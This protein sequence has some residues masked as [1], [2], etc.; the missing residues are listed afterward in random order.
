MAIVVEV[1]NRNGQV[2]R[3]E[4][5]DK[6]LVTVGRAYHCD[7]ILA[8]PHIDAEH[9]VLEHNG[10]T[11]AFLC[12]DKRSLNG[13]WATPRRRNLV[14]EHK[15]RL[16]GRAHIF[17]GQTL[18]LGRTY[19]RV[20]SSH[21]AV[22]PAQPLSRWE[23]VDA[24]LSHWWVCAALALALILLTI[25]DRYLSAPQTG[26]LLQYALN[27]SY[28]LFSAVFYGAFWALV[29]R[30]LGLDAKFATQFSIALTALLLVSVFEFTLPFWLYNLNA[31]HFGQYA[32]QLCFA[33]AVFAALFVTLV[34]VS[35]LRPLTRLCMAALVPLGL[36]VPVLLSVVTRADF[37]PLPNYNRALVA[38]GWQIRPGVSIEEFLDEARKINPDTPE[39]IEETAQ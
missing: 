8:D 15:K 11:G 38:P 21:H 12:Q 22:P 35:R 4:S 31:W 24:F 34:F 6:N 32:S 10:A 17:S 27:S 3:T 36:M 18:L 1:I 16:S 14:G 28:M 37:N 23:T 33:G 26:Q 2:L 25:L 29:G 20:Y 13:T 30:N 7:V 9:L 39:T 19:I 5:V